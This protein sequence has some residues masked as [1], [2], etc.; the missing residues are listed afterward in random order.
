MSIISQ[1]KTNKKKKLRSNETA[2]I[3]CRS[4]QKE[5]IDGRTDVT[6]NIH[7]GEMGRKQQK[8]QI[9]FQ[10]QPST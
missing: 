3:S 4:I 8:Q 2:F 6:M 9:A 10:N 5:G 7:G 1:L